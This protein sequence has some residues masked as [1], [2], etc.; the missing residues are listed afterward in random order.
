MVCLFLFA[1]RCERVYPNCKRDFQNV[2]IALLQSPAYFG[3]VG[4]TG[5][6]MGLVFSSLSAE[7]LQIHPPKYPWSHRGPF[8]ALDHARLDV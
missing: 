1:L 2:N 7:G 6:G 3:A 4:A 5:L 8:S